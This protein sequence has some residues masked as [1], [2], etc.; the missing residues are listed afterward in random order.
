MKCGLLGNIL[1]ALYVY[2][3]EDEQAPGRVVVLGTG[4]V[5]EGGEMGGAVRRLRR[6]RLVPAAAVL[7]AAVLAGCS[8]G[9]STTITPASRDGNAPAGQ[10][11]SGNGGGGKPA[12]PAVPAARL[13]LQPAN[14]STNV[15]PTAPVTIRAAAGRLTTVTV[16]NPAGKK[17]TGSWSTDRTRWTSAEPLGYAKTYTVTATAVN[18]EG[19]PTRLTSRFTTV[20]PVTFTMPFLFPSGV[21]TVGIGQPITVHFDE[22]IADKAAAERA[23]TV[24]TSPHAV[25]GWYWF[26][27]QNAHWRPKSYWKPGTHVTVSAN[28]YGVNVGGGIYGQQDVSTSFTI[29]PARILT[30]ENSTHMGVARVNGKVVRHVPVSMGRGG[31]IRVNGKTIFFSTASGPHVMQE[32]YAI[33]HMDSSTYGLPVNSPL[34]YSEDIPLAIR[35]TADGEFLHAASWSVAQQGV[36]NVSHGCVNISPANAR[37]FY[38]NWGYG[39]IVDI[40]GTGVPLSR[41]NRFG[42]WMITWS[43]WAAGSALH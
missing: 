24:T 4:W 7:L 11:N 27:N 41:T 39:D 9:G 17:V 26:D 38:D 29:G 1:G 22:A 20:T 2:P 19:K 21:K 30:I 18:T 43:E 32:K 15:S 5:G 31:S 13:A 35:L 42:D 16:S 28:L 12:P 36:R 6:G 40:K 37:W 23:L 10:G 8:G 3:R 34:G 33:K 14:G 25:G